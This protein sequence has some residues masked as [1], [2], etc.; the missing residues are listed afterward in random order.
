MRLAV[1]RYLNFADHGFFES[2]RMMDFIHAFFVDAKFRK[3]MSMVSFN[4][5]CHHPAAPKKA[6]LQ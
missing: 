5:G 1:G 3:H 2:P 4:P 6:A